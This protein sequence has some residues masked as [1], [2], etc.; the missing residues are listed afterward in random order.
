[1]PLR[2]RLSPV[3]LRHIQTFIAVAEQGSVSKAALRLHIAQP[4]LSRQINDFEAELG[5]PLFERIHR[6]LIL[7]GAGERLLAD[8][9]A[10]L[11]AVD[12]LSTRAQALSGSDAGVLNVAA[13]MLDEVFATFLHRYAERFP[14]VQVRLSDMVGPADMF[15]RLE[16]GDLHLGI[17]LLRSLRADNH[18][19]ES[20]AL[21]SIEFVAT[22]HAS[23][24]LGSAG[25]IDIADLAAYPLLLL[26]TS[27]EVRKSFDSACRLAGITPRV[28]MESRISHT[29]LTLAEAG[30][31]LA[32]LPSVVPIHRYRLRVAR[33]TQDGNLLLEPLAVLWDGKRVLPSYARSF[34]EMLAVHMQPAFPILQQPAPTRSSRARK[35]GPRSASSAA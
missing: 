17:G 25:H 24:A 7:T 12:S 1:M 4:A 10:I 16:G 34:C 28:F 35:P 6:R 13:T 11:N 30:H 26:N 29:L 5:L 33:I 19:F 27:F 23:I 20:F 22:S 15:A 9:R 21:P 18:R 31:G 32:I 3:K 2:H 8:C 14:N